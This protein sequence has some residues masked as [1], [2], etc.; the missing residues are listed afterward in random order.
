MVAQRPGGVAGETGKQ[1]AA[2]EAARPSTDKGGS[3]PTLDHLALRPAVA[4][5]LDGSRGFGS[6]AA[7]WRGQVDAQSCSQ[8]AQT[9]SRPAGSGTIGVN[10][11]VGSHLHFCSTHCFVVCLGP[12]P[13]PSFSCADPSGGTRERGFD[14]QATA[15]SQ[16]HV[17]ECR[18]RVPHPRIMACLDLKNTL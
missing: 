2:A 7:R 5:W 10:G 14:I 13:A 6:S 8:E 12:S 18:V 1:G 9:T 16:F 4:P 3:K 11:R 15:R 17:Q